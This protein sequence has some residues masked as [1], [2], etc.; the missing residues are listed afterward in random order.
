MDFSK[1]KIHIIGAGGIVKDAHLPAYKIAGYTVDAITNRS[2]E[3]A[4]GLASQYAI[5][6][7]YDTVDDMV[8]VYDESVIYDIALPAC[9]TAAVLR[10]LPTGSFVLIQKPMGETIEEAHEIVQVCREKKMCAGV[11]LQL[12][13]APFI[14]E[15]HKLINSGKIGQ[16]TDFE[17]YINVFTPW[18]LWDFLSN[19][20]RMEILYHSVHYIDLI[21][22][23]FGTPAAV[24]ARTYKHP[25]SPTLSSVRTNIIMDYGDML[26]TTIHTNHNHNYGFKNQESYIKIEGTTGAIKMEIGVLKQYPIGTNDSMEYA[27]IEEGKNTEWIQ[28]PLSG[29]W[30]PHA[31]IGTMQQMM[32]AKAGKISTPNNSVEDVLDTMKCVEAAYLSNDSGGVRIQAIQ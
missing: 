25:L 21:R 23:F 27:C 29:T 1:Y 15:A 3:K 31:F 8:Q 26:R 13:Y 9:D 12:R 16:V 6:A 11:N 24:M 20:P 2:K 30:F 7:V 5:P 17:V 18:H 4:A 28:V 14:Q 22:S 10:K 19:K 32:L